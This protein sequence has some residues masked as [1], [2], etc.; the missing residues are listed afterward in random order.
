MNIRTYLG[1]FPKPVLLL[2]LATMVESTGR[3]MVVPYLSLHL[4]GEGISLGVL[5][6]VLAA[7][8]VA[9][10]IFGVWGG[11]LSDR[12]GRQPVQLIGVWSSALALFGF[13]F[14]GK[15]P[16]LLAALNFLNGMTRTFYRPATSAAIADFSPPLK[17]SEAF[18]LNRIALN[19][20]FGWGPLLG[21]AV[22]SWSP[23]AGFLI[24][25]AVNL[26]AGI[27]I[28]T[29]VPESL[30]PERRTKKPDTGIGIQEW[31]TILTDGVFWAWILGMALITGAYDLIQSFL[32]LHLAD[33]GVPL[34]VY[35]SLLTLNALVCVFGQLPVSR[36][37]RS[38]PISSVSFLSKIGYALGFLALA[39]LRSPWL[40]V[41]AMLVLSIAEICG[42]AVQVR[43]LPERALTHLLGRYHGL[44]TITE[45]G[46]AFSALFAG[47]LMERSGGSSV[48]VAAAI[49]SLLG[50]VV[51]YFAGVGHERGS[52]DNPI[53]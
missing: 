21:V 10:V 17:R 49:L 46:R 33:Q 14:A 3:F 27:F 40:L 4:R 45:I 23:R 34:W 1:S 30:P 37:L 39:Y 8:P 7:S 29:T 19:A 43:F 53:G 12:W 50:G 42:A 52:T 44:F 22:F 47:L 20:A 31:R 35:G 32:P 26:L 24:G 9:S 13:A 16:V 6:L 11:A 51:L 36:L 48:F 5:G 28:A 15:L 41:A 38:A 2:V 18:A 25:G